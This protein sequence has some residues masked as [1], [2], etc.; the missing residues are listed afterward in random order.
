MWF[1]V[2]FHAIFCILNRVF[3]W[4]FIV[5]CY[6]PIDKS[7]IIVYYVAIKKTMTSDKGGF[8]DEGFGHDFCTGIYSYGGRCFPYGLA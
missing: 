5:F 6:F 2:I 1:Y 8:F 4:F 3:L 7:K